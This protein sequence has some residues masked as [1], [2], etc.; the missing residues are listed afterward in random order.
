MRSILPWKD[1]AELKNYVG[2]E[3]YARLRANRHGCFELPGGSVL[4]L[5]RYCDVTGADQK[6]DRICVYCSEQALIYLCDNARCASLAAQTDETAGPFQQLLDF[7][8]A[9]TADDFDALDKLEEEITGLEDYLITAIRPEKS[10]SGKIITLR[11]QL[12]AL[13]RYYE[14][15]SFV[16]HTLTEN[17][18]LPKDLLKHYS[19]LR[20]R[21]DRLFD[22]VL[23]LREYITQVREAYQAQ[24]DIEQNQ[25]MKVFTV[26]TAVFLPL[27]LIVGWYGMNFNIPEYAWRFG[28]PYVIILSAVVCS[29]CFLYFR[30]K[31]WF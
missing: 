31:K 24:I 19:G 10:F 2:P 22:S 17:I 1:M 30:R 14:Q 23:H 8:L 20:R 4:L 6:D 29:V 16:I 27:T 13:K 25:L 18:A 15:L 11:R 21:I 12:L 7:F 3:H 5:F 9:L 26:I 28:Y